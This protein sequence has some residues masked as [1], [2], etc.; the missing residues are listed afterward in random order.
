MKA[1]QL[2]VAKKTTATKTT[3]KKPSASKR[4]SKPPEKPTPPGLGEH[5]ATDPQTL[6][7][8]AV[9]LL[10]PKLTKIHEAGAALSAHYHDN[11]FADAIGRAASLLNMATN[12]VDEDVHA[13][14]IFAEGG[15]PMSFADI[16]SRLKDI[17]W[18]RPSSENTIK[19][20]VEALLRAA[21]EQIEKWNDD[22]CMLIGQRMG[23]R[24]N[25]ETLRRRLVRH[26][27]SMI[28]RSS[29]SRVV[30]DS[31][32]CAEG[33]ADFIMEL[34]NVKNPWLREALSPEH[35]DRL[36]GYTTFIR[37]VCNG[38]CYEEF[39]GE[40]HWDQ[41]LYL[42][43]VD[44][45]VFYLEEISTGSSESSRTPL[46]VRDDL[47]KLNRLIR[48]NADVP[49]AAGDHLN[50]CIEKLGENGPDMEAAKECAAKAAAALIPHRDHWRFC[51]WWRSLP[52]DQI[53]IE[54]GEG[55]G[56]MQAE[57][58]DGAATA[59]DE[60]KQSLLA[61]LNEGDS[62]TADASG[63]H[64]LE[65]CTD[66]QNRIREFASTVID[67]IKALT[68]PATARM[69]KMLERIAQSKDAEL[70][71]P[72]AS[73]KTKWSE[74]DEL[75]NA[76]TKY[77][78]DRKVRPYELFLFAA[79]QGLMVDKLVAKRSELASGFHPASRYTGCLS[80]L[81]THLGAANEI[82]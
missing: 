12:P 49:Q 69:T 8:L 43:R 57:T 67:T 58:E 78:G 33:T 81:G 39:M 79:Q 72:A 13:Y 82:E 56:A 28:S 73:N 26:V 51:D 18:S 64:S 47:Q 21:H 74:V 20:Y 45:I 6:A 29:L 1:T 66:L 5:A 77:S 40:N 34:M 19:A 70:C 62:L 23:Y 50:A 15:D 27:A 52:V 2:A 11:D 14:Q 10:Q 30:G 46:Q 54:L 32:K 60:P 48:L 76:L 25:L 35:T 17:G 38:L 65:E 71:P 59:A 16:E 75:L 7:T 55:V 44:T 22:F 53:K 36:R 80:I 3:G 31:C 63:G 61:L 41:C 4:A 42:D 24:P 9:L 68:G 37:Y